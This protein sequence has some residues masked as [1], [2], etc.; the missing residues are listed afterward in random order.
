[1]GRG[2]FIIGAVVGAV[3]GVVAGFLTAPKSGKDTRTG[4][5]RKAG[6]LKRDAAQRIHEVEGR[7]ESAIK[8]IKEKA[9][10]YKQRSEHAIEGAKE[11][12]KTDTKK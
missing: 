6:E 8:D 5:K 4:I 10:D 2:R 1:M 12:F 3:A 7:G 11:G 9:Q